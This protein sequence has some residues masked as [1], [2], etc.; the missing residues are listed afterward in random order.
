[1]LEETRELHVCTRNPSGALGLKLMC[2]FFMTDCQV[3]EPQGHNQAERS[4]NVRMKS[5]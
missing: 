3:H 5:Y 1:M 4:A 2:V